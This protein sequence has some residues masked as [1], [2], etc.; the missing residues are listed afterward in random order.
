MTVRQH[1]YDEIQVLIQ[2]YLNSSREVFTFVSEI[3][4][5]MKN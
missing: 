4:K 5:R 2:N 3:R 1:I